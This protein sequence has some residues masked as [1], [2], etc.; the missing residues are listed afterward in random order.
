[1]TTVGP[2]AADFK[3]GVRAENDRRSFVSV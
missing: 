1:M 3:V 2:R